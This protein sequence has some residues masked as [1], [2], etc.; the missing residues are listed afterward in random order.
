MVTG[1][2]IGLVVPFIAMFA[3]AWLYI[4]L[5]LALPMI[6]DDN[7]FRLFEAWKISKPA[8]GKLTLLAL[9]IVGIWFVLMLLTFIGYA[10]VLSGAVG[11]SH[12]GWG[13]YFG[14]PGAQVAHDVV[15]LIT[16]IGA[17]IVFISAPTQ[18]LCAGAWADAYRQLAP[19][20]SVDEVFA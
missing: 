11:A 15:P 8:Q 6:V 17:V 14:R 1:L 9:A 10:A 12:L 4:R 18:A 5:S 3:I 7:R 20:R 2:V 13:G 19:G 16:A